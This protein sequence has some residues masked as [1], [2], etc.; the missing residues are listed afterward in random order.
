MGNRNSVVAMKASHECSVCGWPLIKEYPPFELVVDGASKTLEG[1]PGWRCRSCG[2]I[3]HDTNDVLNAK[4]IVRAYDLGLYTNDLPAALL[5]YTPI[6]G[7]EA[8]PIPGKT[9]FQKELWYLSKGTENTSFPRPN[10][11][12]MQGGPWDPNLD[13][14]L[15][16]MQ[17]KG[18][19]DVIKTNVSKEKTAHKYRLT[20]TGKEKIS[21]IWQTLPDSVRNK[22]V[23]VKSR[24]NNLT[25]EEIVNL[26][27]QEFPKMWDKSKLERWGINIEEIQEPP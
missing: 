11:M 24:L 14:R 26:V 7:K 1:V 4:A 17:S 23:E 22:L 19:L 2:E 5:L 8:V 25:A 13:M 12:P 15:E 20:A 6:E 27:H 21:R 16:R 9:V 18:L 3:Y 10:F